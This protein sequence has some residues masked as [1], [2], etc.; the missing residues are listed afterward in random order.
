MAQ[1]SS[2]GFL[3]GVDRMV[4]GMARVADQLSALVC[5]ILILATAVTMAVFQMGINI[6]GI[7]DILRM[8][9]IWLVY[10]GA[11]SLS[12]DGDHISMDA[13]YQVLPD[14]ARRIVDVLISLFGIGLSLFVAKFGLDSMLTDIDYEMTLPSG[15]L[16]EWPQSLAIPLCFALMAVAYLSYLLSVL[17]GRRYRDSGRADEL[18]ELTKGS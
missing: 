3:H 9:L 16:P 14:R 13:V 4:H 6:V 17:T 8:L 2:P 12:L 11:V 18:T 15:Y 5:A 10:L 1:R 7:D